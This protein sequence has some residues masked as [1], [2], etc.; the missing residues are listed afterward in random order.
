MGQDKGR[1]VRPG[2][3]VSADRVLQ[4]SDSECA[5]RNGRGKFSLVSILMTVAAWVAL[6]YNGRLAL[7]MSIIGI[8]VGCFG[9]RASSR[10]WRNTAITS[11]LAS[12]VLLVVVSA[13][14]IV[15]F[16]GLNSV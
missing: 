4:A 3:S 12:A 8:I 11:I 16:V 10:A 13:F 9:L 15:I 7:V 14:L 6:S 1:V 5:G 2:G